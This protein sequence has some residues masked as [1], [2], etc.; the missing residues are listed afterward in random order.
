MRGEPRMRS[1]RVGG[2]ST[3]LLRARLSARFF[4]LIDPPNVYRTVVN[5]RRTCQYRTRPFKLRAWKPLETNRSSL[6]AP[7]RRD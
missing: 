5:R 3:R 4:A 2:V 7:A 1:K 6:S